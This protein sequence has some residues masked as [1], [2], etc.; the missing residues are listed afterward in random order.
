MRTARA[1]G[2]VAQA[3]PAL[4]QALGEYIEAFSAHHPKVAHAHEG[5]AEVFSERGEFTKME[6]HLD[7][8]IGIRRKVQEMGQGHELFKAELDELISRK[9]EL[10][11]RKKLKALGE[12]GSDRR[13]SRRWNKTLALVS[14]HGHSHAS[15]SSPKNKTVGV[16]TQPQGSFRSLVRLAKAQSEVGAAAPAPAT[17]PPRRSY[18][19]HPRF[20]SSTSVEVLEEGADAPE[21]AKTPTADV[22]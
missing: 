4:F 18:S 5:I 3:E 12:A 10:A 20:V 19:A 17:V 11:S 7:A 15:G 13:A 2:L 21:D 6:E 8:A 1:R 16:A 14:F 9:E 22:V